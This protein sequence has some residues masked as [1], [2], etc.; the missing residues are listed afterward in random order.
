MDKRHIKF[1][2]VNCVQITHSRENI[3]AVD[4]ISNLNMYEFSFS[5]FVS[6]AFRSILTATYSYV[7]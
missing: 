3:S 7:R 1:V 2:R 4:V 5:L 6:T